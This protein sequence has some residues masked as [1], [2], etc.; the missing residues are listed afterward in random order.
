MSLYAIFAFSAS[1]GLILNVAPRSY[2]VRRLH[3]RAPGAHHPRLPVQD[4]LWC[5]FHTLSR[6]LPAELIWICL[7]PDGRAESLDESGK[8]WAVYFNDISAVLYFRYVRENV[9]VV[10]FETLAG[11]RAD[12]LLCGRQGKE[13]Q[14]HFFKEFEAACK[15]K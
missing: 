14:F 10:L 7:L 2:F 8:D 6:A 3:Q 12:P 4:H 15:N 5:V 1:A 13:F 11:S 9:R